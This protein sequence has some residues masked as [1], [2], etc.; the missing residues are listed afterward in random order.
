MQLQGA[1]TASLVFHALLFAAMDGLHKTND[2]LE[3]TA[4][5][6]GRRIYLS[7]SLNTNVAPAFNDGEDFPKVL[8]SKPSTP[9]NA[10]DGTPEPKTTPAHHPESEA[11]PS[12]TL[13]PHYYTHHELDRPPRLI[14]NLDNKNGP[15]EMA[16]KKHAGNGTVILEYLVNDQ[17]GID[18]LTILHSTLPPEMID[19][20]REHAKSVSFIPGRLDR[21]PVP[22]K[23]KIELIIHETSD[24]SP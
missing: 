9:G 20:V 11:T 23:V 8:S 18:R 3:S 17:G 22:S 6:I 7:A 21:Q 14:E 13:A 12:A 19:I 24:Q 2:H 16:L 15:L 10:S 1:V 5:V 4:S